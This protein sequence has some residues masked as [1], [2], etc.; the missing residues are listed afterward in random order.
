MSAIIT[1]GGERI[2][3][4]RKSH[5][6]LRS[7]KPKGNELKESIRTE[8]KLLVEFGMDSI[9]LRD[10]CFDLDSFSLY[11][12][13]ILLFRLSICYFFSLS[14]FAVSKYCLYQA[15]HCPI[16]AFLDSCFRIAMDF[17][18]NRIIEIIYI[19]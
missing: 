14:Q 18:K 12:I 10:N 6:L 2:I 5:Q 3:F 13:Y 16:S 4:D 17:L 9:F 11:T 19:P 15:T 8:R 1:R 7:I